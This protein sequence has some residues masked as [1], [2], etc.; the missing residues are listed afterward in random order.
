MYIDTGFCSCCPLGDIYDSSVGDT[1]TIRT[2]N[3]YL[4]FANSAG[5]DGFISRLHYCYQSSSTPT[6]EVAEA[7]MA[8]YR[9]DGLTVNRVSDEFIITNSGSTGSSTS[10]SVCED[11]ELQ[12]SIP[13]TTGDILGVCLLR[14]T[15]G[16]EVL[17]VVSG[18]RVRTPECN[19]QPVDS[20]SV[21]DYSVFNDFNLHI[22]ANVTPG[23]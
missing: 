10:G 4:D 5:C 12:T 22:S 8:V 20:V 11:Y 6:S 2:G 9:R 15:P 13:V 19:A 23:M 1:Q 17:H 16:S 3:F 18:T 21:F 7:R 14:A